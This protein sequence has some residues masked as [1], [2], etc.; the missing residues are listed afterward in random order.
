MRKQVS[1][2]TCLAGMSDR[3]LGSRLSPVLANRMDGDADDGDSDGR[4]L[5]PVPRLTDMSSGPL[6][7]AATST[8]M[9]GC[10]CANVSTCPMRVMD[11]VHN[12]I[13]TVGANV[14][15]CPMRVMV[16][17]HNRISTVGANVST[18]PWQQSDR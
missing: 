9:S 5:G 10:A 11:S 14:S 15:T 16:S 12:R 1:T 18:C 13:L 8:S 2:P 7:P 6:L 4:R 3:V 17:V